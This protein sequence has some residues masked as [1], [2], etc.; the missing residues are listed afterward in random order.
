MAAMKP[1]GT[2]GS[3]AAMESSFAASST[4]V[5]SLATAADLASSAAL[6]TVADARIAAATK[7]SGRQI[8]RRDVGCMGRPSGTEVMRVTLYHARTRPSSERRRLSADEQGIF[9]VG[10]PAVSGTQ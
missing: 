3:A 9:L 4:C 2:E 5:S 1:P 8:A 10:G 6:A 7:T